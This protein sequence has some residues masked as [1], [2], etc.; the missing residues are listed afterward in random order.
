MASNF[1]VLILI[2]VMIILFLYFRSKENNGIRESILKSF[3]SLGL[4]IWL[5]TEI[6]GVLNLLYEYVFQI[7]YLCYLLL[8]VLFLE[9]QKKGF[10]QIISSDF[11]VIKLEINYYFKG[12]VK[13]LF[14]F[15]LATTL[16]LSIYVA[17][18]NTDALGYHIARVMFWAQNHNLYHY[19]TEF[20]PQLYYNVL[21]EYF[22]LNLYLLTGS[23]Y[24]FN[25]VQWLAMLITL[26]TTSKILQV[27]SAKKEVQGLGV[28]FTLAIPQVILQSTSSQNDLLS[29]SYFIISVFFGYNIVVNKFEYSDYCWALVALLLGGFTKYSVLVIG[30]P[31]I[32]FFGVYQIYINPRRAFLLGLLSLLFFIG[33]FGLFFYRNYILMSQIIAPTAGSPLFI[34]NYTSEIMN[35]K[36]FISNLIKISGNH[37]SLP[38]YFWNTWYDHWVTFVH[39]VIDFPLN[40]RLNSFGD[41]TTSFTIGEDFS[42]NFIHFLLFLICVALVLLK[43]SI[44]ERPQVRL[45]VLLFIGF[46]I[47]SLI[48]KWQ[49]FHA[50]TQMP[51]FVVVAPIIIFFISEKFRLTEKKI[52]FL[53]LFFLLSGLPYLIFNSIKPIIPISY[54]VKC[55][56]HYLPSSL[57]SK[58]LDSVSDRKLVKLK[59]FKHER[60]GLQLTKVTNLSSELNSLGFSILD[61]NGVFDQDKLWVGTLPDRYSHY[62]LYNHARF[63]ELKTIFKLIG[64]R[65]KHIGFHSYS[66]FVSPF[67][68]MGKNYIGEDF[69]LKYIKYSTIFDGLKNTDPAYQYDAILTDDYNFAKKLPSNIGPIFRLNTWVIVLLQKPSIKVYH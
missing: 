3:L 28:L 22:F 24:F 43:K 16:F 20:T 49:R 12:L 37:L 53:A 44:W 40:S 8:G 64:N 10:M 4:L 48:F 55:S 39:R 42:G 6:L 56:I 60:L 11:N 36:S 5:T 23:D 1:L 52:Y 66:S 45:F 58:Q 51:F 18:N 21:S 46:C 31:L 62:V 47:Y 38:F 14:F 69:Q 26:V 67:F 15:F 25:C 33:I 32:C 54:V 57:S 27:W 34:G 13:H 9:A 17:P 2:G 35:W 59:I 65:R 41:Y 19:P 68:I 29:A 63:N 30:F 7:V 50:R 61:R